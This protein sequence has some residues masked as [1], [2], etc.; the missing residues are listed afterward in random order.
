M[1]YC[2]PDVC[3]SGYDS[4]YC[5]SGQWFHDTFLK[6]ALI[7]YRFSLWGSLSFVLFDNSIKHLQGRWPVILTFCSSS[8]W[9]CVTLLAID[10]FSWIASCRPVNLFSS[11]PRRSSVFS[12]SN[13]CWCSYSFCS[14]SSIFSSVLHQHLKFFFSNFCYLQIFNYFLWLRFAIAFWTIVSCWC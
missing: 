9:M 11:S 14:F 2:K 12:S 6:D 10:W 7:Q 1:T 8:Y 5:S 3:F 4:I 13:F